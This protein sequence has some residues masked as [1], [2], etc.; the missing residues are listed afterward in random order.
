MSG[1]AGHAASWAAMSFRHCTGRIPHFQSHDQYVVLV[2]I[3]DV[4]WVVVI[5]T[6]IVGA[7]YPTMQARN[8]AAMPGTR[9]ATPVV[10][11][12]LA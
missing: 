9:R 2:G 7:P 12:V 11:V 3:G 4:L 1:F 10:R 6:Y 8:I 5:A